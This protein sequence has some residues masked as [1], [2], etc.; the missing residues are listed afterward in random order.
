[1]LWYI[2]RLLFVIIIALSGVSMFTYAQ[3]DNTANPLTDAKHS[4]WAHKVAVIGLKDA[5]NENG[6]KEDA[7]VN[8]IKWWVNW[9]L[10]IL[11]LIALIILMYGWFL[12]VTAAWDDEKYKKWWTILKHAAIWLILIG[13]AWFIISLIFWLVNKTAY[14]V[15]WANSDT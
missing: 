11:A 6:G 2:H 3:I 7:L 15:E 10:W 8:V 14:W 12:M 5:S 4:W 13:V 9:V 1:M